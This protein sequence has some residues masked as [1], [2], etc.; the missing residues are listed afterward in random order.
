MNGDKLLSGTRPIVLPAPVYF[1][2]IVVAVTAGVVTCGLI[3][4]HLALRRAGCVGSGP[5]TIRMLV[6]HALL[7][8][9]VITIAATR[10]AAV[11]DRYLWP[12]VL[13][14]AILVLHHCRRV[15][16]APSPRGTRT[17]RGI[18][19]VVVVVGFVTAIAV[20]LPRTRTRST[21]PAGG[22]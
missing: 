20:V 17:A 13:S 9:G 2:L 11:F 6:A 16:Y 10:N 8:A 12:I 3:V 14:S 5:P 18:M 7:A 22:S 15:E 19:V 1:L 21:E 4:E